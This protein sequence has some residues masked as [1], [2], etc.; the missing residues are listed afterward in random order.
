MYYLDELVDRAI[1]VLLLLSLVVISI[2][3]TLNYYYILRKRK[4]FRFEYYVLKNF[5]TRFFPSTNLFRRIFL[6]YFLICI[7]TIS[8]IFIITYIV[9]WK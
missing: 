9:N 6:N 1:I 4:D 8:I 5:D 2:L 7:Y 3:I